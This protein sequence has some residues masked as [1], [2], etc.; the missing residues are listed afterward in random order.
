MHR[1]QGLRVPQVLMWLTDRPVARDL[2]PLQSL[3]WSDSGQMV[4][5]FSK[6]EDAATPDS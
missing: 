1:L 5:C 3:T 6:M 2:E 4:L